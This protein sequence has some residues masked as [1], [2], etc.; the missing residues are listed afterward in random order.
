MKKIEGRPV[1]IAVVGL[2]MASKPH[3]LALKDLADGRVEV[4]KPGATR[5]DEID[6]DAQHASNVR[7]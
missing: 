7:Q 3:V 1:R 6:A 4:E 2:G 5:G